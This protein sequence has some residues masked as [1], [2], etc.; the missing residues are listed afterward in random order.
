MLEKRRRQDQGTRKVR[1]P[2]RLVY[3]YVK[4]GAMRLPLRR[5]TDR[6]HSRYAETCGPWVSV[7]PPVQ[8]FGCVDRVLIRRQF[9]S[10]GGS[11][12]GGGGPG[13]GGAGTG[14][15]RRKNRNQGG[16]N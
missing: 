4:R 1:R 2:P 3:K 8:S 7:V 9:Y 10:G 11:G 5:L 16:R 12:G 13:G 14:R 15:N 6:W